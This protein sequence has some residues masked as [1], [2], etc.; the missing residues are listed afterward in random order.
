MAP[1]SSNSDMLPERSTMT[2][3]E[4]ARASMAAPDVSPIDS[5]RNCTAMSEAHNQ[6]SYVG[7]SNDP[8]NTTRWSAASARRCASYPSGA[9]PPM[10]ASIESVVE[11]GIWL[12]ARTSVSI[13]LCGATSPN[14]A[15]TTHAGSTPSAAFA[16]AMEP[17]A[18]RNNRRGA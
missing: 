11:R 17:A 4:C 10:M 15:M 5:G 9:P 13:P 1:S 7:S 18:S 6:R 14:V 3:Q 16:S 12:N 8:V 2:A